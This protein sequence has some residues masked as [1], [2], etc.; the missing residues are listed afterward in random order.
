MRPRN[1]LILALVLIGLG[2]YLYFVESERIA[3]EAKKETLV[4]LNID[5]VT[6]VTLVYPDRAIALEK[7][8]AGWR[9]TKPVEA[10]ADDVTVKNLLRAIAD[11]EVKKTIDDPPQDLTQFGLAPPVA[12]IKVT[13]KDQSLPDLKVGKT[14]AVSFSTY[15]QRADQPKLYLTGSAFHAGMDKQVKDLRDKKIV[16]F[17]ED[18][19][20]RIALRGPDGDVVLAKVEGTWTIEQP[21]AYRADSNAVRALLSTVRNLRATDFASDAPSDT[22]L[23]TYGLDPP[24][25]Q[26]ELTTADG[27]ATRM[28]VGNEVEQGLYVKTGDRPTTFIVGKYVSR[29]LAK[30]VGDLRDKTVL[31]FDPGS[32]TAVEV[33]RGDGGSFTLRSADGKWSLEGSDQALNDEAIGSFVAALS[34]LAGNQVLGEAPTDLGA[35]GLADPALTITVKGKD[36]MLIGSVRAGSRS[37]NPPATEYTI[38]RED[39]PTV[40]E[41]RDFQY[42]QLDKQPGDFL[43]EPDA[44]PVEEPKE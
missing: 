22:D 21:A 8:D 41:L 20:S 43:A 3:K 37:P 44:P 30:G 23:V 27:K 31:S 32:V 5:D 14:T 39:E 2:A 38:K 11:A 15:V 13:V 34:R 4:E 16:D 7:S 6:A 36:D 35:Y 17:K 12:T 10:A 40:F 33:A 25:R 1:T 29:D 24:Q 26:L 18:D 42:K 9:L 28:L 19:V